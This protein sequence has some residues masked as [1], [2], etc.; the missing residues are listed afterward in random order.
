MEKIIKIFVLLI[1]VSTI[2]FYNTATAQYARPGI[3]LGLWGAYGRSDFKLENYTQAAHI[4]VGLS[5]MYG[6]VFKAG[7]EASSNHFVPL[8]FNYMN[9]NG[10]KE[11]ESQITQNNA[12]VV[13]M[14]D[15]SHENAWGPL[16]RIGIGHYSGKLRQVYN[17]TIIQQEDQMEGFNNSLGYNFGL[18]VI[19]KLGDEYSGTGILIEYI[20]HFIERETENLTLPKFTANSWEIRA[21]VRFDLQ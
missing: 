5:I 12:S 3:N 8:T 7:L 20:Y 21:G 13:G 11:Y 4:P 1:S 17:Q 2:F 18:G 16:F 14:L 6:G 10:E 19:G 9:S 15:F